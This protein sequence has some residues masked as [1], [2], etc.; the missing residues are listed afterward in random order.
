MTCL[1]LRHEQEVALSAL[2]GRGSMWTSPLIFLYGQHACGK[3]EVLM[4]VLNE[5][6]VI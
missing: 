2:L 1:L 5:A 4:K 3:S 6:K